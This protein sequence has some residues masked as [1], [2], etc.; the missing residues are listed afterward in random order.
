MSDVNATDDLEIKIQEL[1]E[2]IKRE[3]ASY[4]SPQT[5]IDRFNRG[6]S[7]EYGSKYVKIMTDGSVWGF[8]SLGKDKKFQRGDILKAANWKTP[9]KNAARGNLYRDYRVNWTGPYYLR[10]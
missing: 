7:Y 4:D 3:Y 9:A 8:I 5:M 1:I 6:L 2:V 10:G